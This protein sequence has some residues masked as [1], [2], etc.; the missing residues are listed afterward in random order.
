MVRMFLQR[1]QLLEAGSVLKQ[2]ENIN[3]DAE[4]W[5]LRALYFERTGNR[6][7]RQRMLEQALKTDPGNAEAL[8]MQKV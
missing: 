3:N 2:L 7:E 8:N 5:V 1:N 6:Q 4:L